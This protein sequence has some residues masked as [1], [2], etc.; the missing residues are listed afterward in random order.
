[1]DNKPMTQKEI[2]ENYPKKNLALLENAESQ[3]A[4]FLIGKGVDTETT[5]LACYWLEKTMNNYLLTY[6]LD[7]HEQGIDF[8]KKPKNL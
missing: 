2:L 3:L 4:S 5:R 6:L 1:M 7:L 8:T